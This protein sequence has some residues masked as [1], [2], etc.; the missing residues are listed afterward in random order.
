MEIKRDEWF[1]SIRW[2]NLIVGFMNL[3]LYVYGGGYHLLALGTIN[4]AVWVF[5]RR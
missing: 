1:N 2:F 5:T 4:I 3:Y